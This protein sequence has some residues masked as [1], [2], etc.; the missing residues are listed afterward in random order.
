MCTMEV[1]AVSF[2]YFVLYSIYE[3]CQNNSVIHFLGLG[4]ELEFMDYLGSE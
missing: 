1:P 2:Y 4:E 3:I